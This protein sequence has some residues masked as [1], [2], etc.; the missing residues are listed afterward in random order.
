MRLKNKVIAFISGISDT[1][2][3]PCVTVIKYKGEKIMARTTRRLCL[4]LLSAALSMALILC[5]FPTAAPA[6]NHEISAGGTYS[7]SDYTFSAGDTLTIKEGLTVTI[8]GSATNISI[9]CEPNVNLTI[10]GLALPSPPVTI[11]AR[12]LLQAG[13]Q[14]R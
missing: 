13:P 6:A 10:N 12:S 4:S 11:L 1:V 9:L 8:S 3:L 5:I 2:F 7:L 14:I